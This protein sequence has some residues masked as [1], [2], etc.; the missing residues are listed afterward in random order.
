MRTPLIWETLFSSWHLI[1]WGTLVVCGPTCILSFPCISIFQP[2]VALCIRPWLSKHSAAELF[3]CLVFVFFASY[4]FTLDRSLESSVRS[5]S[6]GITRRRSSGE[7]LRRQNACERLSS[8]S[9]LRLFVCH[10]S[11][12]K[13]WLEEVFLLF[14][15]PPTSSPASYIESA[16]SLLHFG[17]GANMYI[18]HFAA[19]SV[20]PCRSSV[21]RWWMRVHVTRL[22]LACASVFLEPSWPGCRSARPLCDCCIIAAFL[23]CLFGFRLHW[24]FFWLGVRFFAGL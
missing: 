16:V 22:Y 19:I 23:S 3:R 5:R 17:T 2:L 10:R 9:V 13:T 21:S 20:T 18:T 15:K 1:F 6:N 11:L 8:N 7:S 12:A 4:C 24:A 14:K